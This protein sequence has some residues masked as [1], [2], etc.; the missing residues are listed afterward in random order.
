MNSVRD[1]RRYH[2]M[3]WRGGAVRPNGFNG[4]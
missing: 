4:I 3:D 1:C 2:R